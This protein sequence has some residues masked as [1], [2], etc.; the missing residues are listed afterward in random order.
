MCGKAMPQRVRM[1]WFLNPRPPGRLVAGMPN[2]FPIDRLI[3]AMVDLAGK[4]PG[5]GSGAQTV[6]VLTKFFEQPGTEHHVAVLASLAALDVNHHALLVEV[7]E[8]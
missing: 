1:Y 5:S 7:A 2:G 6:P 4:E 8:L 3:S